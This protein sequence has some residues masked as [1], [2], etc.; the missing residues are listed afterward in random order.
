MLGRDRDG[1]DGAATISAPRGAIM[2]P[3]PARRQS[4]D[5][6]VRV[7][8]RPRARN[9]AL[10]TL[11]LALA[12]CARSAPAPITPET[13]V[14]S[15]PSEAAPARLPADPAPAAASETTTPPPR[16][17]PLRADAVDVAPTSRSFA[18]GDRRARVFECPG[19]IGPVDVAV[20]I[21]RCHEAT[22]I[23]DSNWLQEMPD[24][25]SASVT[26][27]SFGSEGNPVLITNRQ[28]FGWG[29]T[30]ASAI[31]LANGRCTPTRDFPG[32]RIA[33]EGG[34]LRAWD[35]AESSFARFGLA[36]LRRVYVYRE[37]DFVPDGAPTLEVNYETWPCNDASLPTV[38]AATAAPDGG[39]LALLRHGT[40]EILAHRAGPEESLLLQVRSG[41]AIG[42][43]KD[44]QQTCLD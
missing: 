27:A 17:P 30:I 44:P 28:P 24:W 21:D 36:E 43:L 26:A 9:V 23:P 1:G 19:P 3:M 2:L 5:D 38:D 31:V 33:V 22:L 12:A 34:S 11:L 32:G 4:P 13:V 20:L 8:P 25:E 39:S 7:D 16:C 42:W 41:G 40:L 29:S 35:G 15:G 10:P 14:G 6:L 37:G 18:F